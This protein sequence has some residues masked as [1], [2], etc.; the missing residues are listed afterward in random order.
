MFSC[1][2]SDLRPAPGWARSCGHVHLQPPPPTDRRYPAT[3]RLLVAE[4]IARYGWSYD[5]RDREALAGC[6][7]PDGVWEGLLMGRDRIGP[8]AGRESIA[9]FL[10]EFWQEQSDQR[11]HVFTNVVVSFTDG[12]EIGPTNASAHAYLV[13][14]AASGGAMTAVTTGPYRFEHVREP[15]GVW[16]I[17]RLSAGFDAPF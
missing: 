10:G 11:R 5:E 8:V 16:R 13:L 14:T 1:T 7:T 2:M 17:A 9:D 3:D 12:D 6:F 4:C 15:D